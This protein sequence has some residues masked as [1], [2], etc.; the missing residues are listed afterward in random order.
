MANEMRTFKVQ[1]TNKFGNITYT[2]VQ[3]QSP[4][5]LSQARELAESMYGGN[6]NRITL[7][8]VGIS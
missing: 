2:T 8:A 6:G 7:L 1:I 5:G 3:V 4:A